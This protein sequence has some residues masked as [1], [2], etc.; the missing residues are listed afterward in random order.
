GLL[1]GRRARPSPQFAQLVVPTGDADARTVALQPSQDPSFPLP[2]PRPGVEALFAE[3]AAEV[4]AEFAL[5]PEL[6]RNGFLPL[7]GDPFGSA[8]EK[9]RFM[10]PVSTE[11][12]GAAPMRRFFD[13][14]FPRRSS[15]V[16]WPVAYT[17]RCCRS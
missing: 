9:F 13:I 8:A 7:E 2:D 14:S 5:L 17:V 3:L 4:D 12:A 1:V 6:A 15:A 11:R 10:R 16:Q